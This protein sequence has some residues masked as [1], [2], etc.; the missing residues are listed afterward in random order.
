MSRRLLTAWFGGEQDILGATRAAR[1]AGYEILDVHTPYAVHGLDTAAGLKPSRL[2]WICFALGLS[3][4]VAKLWYQIWTSATSWP[5]N[6]G[7]KPLKSVPAFVPVTFEMMVLFAAV[8]TVVA[9]FI[10]SG[11]RP[12]R[13][14][15]H[16]YDRTTNDL[17]ALVLVQHDA[18]FDPGSVRGLLS[19]F[20]LLRLE[21]RTELPVEMTA[22]GTF[23]LKPVLGWGLAGA[24]AVI[25]ALTYLLPRTF[26]EP[27]IEFLPG[28]VKSVPY[29]PLSVN[30]NF[31]D[32]K[33]L[34][35]PVAGTIARGYLPFDSTRADI[36]AS[37]V[38]G[39][40]A[41]LSPD[42]LA[43]REGKAAAVFATF[44]QPCHG[45]A[46]K[47]DGTVPARGYPPPPALDAANALKLTDGRIFNI[48]TFGR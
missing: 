42:Q 14:P 1:D 6:V 15:R 10:V 11:L 24:L 20:N 18:G 35:T 25:V 39:G 7:G 32:D 5:V 33:T 19:S 31:A 37:L 47:G 29:D 9:F 36:E 38:A 13:K 27:N 23:F 46:G 17:F 16:I 48:L 22:P 26:T 8:G 2:P 21:E 45:P 34:R 4:A 40:L 41:R 12:G 44:C 43:D 28:M 30:P 3:G